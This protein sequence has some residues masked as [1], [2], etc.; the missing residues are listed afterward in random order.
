[1]RPRDFDLGVY[2]VTDRA[3]CGARSVEDVVSAAIDAFKKTWVPAIE[4]A[5]LK[6][7]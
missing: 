6:F 7:D 2:L 5:N 1:M 4:K 3:C